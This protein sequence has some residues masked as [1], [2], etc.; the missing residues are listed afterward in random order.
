MNQNTQIV[1]SF[2]Y[3]MNTAERDR[4][5][6][7]G[8]GCVDVSFFAEDSDGEFQYVTISFENVIAFRVWCEPSKPIDIVRT[9]GVLCQVFKDQWFSDAVSMVA[10][11]VLPERRRDYVHYRMNFS[12]GRCYEVAAS[13]W[14]VRV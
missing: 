12:D 14:A 9:A 10:D 11:R 6:L 1:H 7:S 13:G 3:D 4:L 2:S 8:S 5:Q